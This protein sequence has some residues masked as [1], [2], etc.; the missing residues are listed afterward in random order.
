M[1][2]TQLACGMALLCLTT[3][4]YT[5]VDRVEEFK[6]STRNQIE[7][8]KSWNDMRRVYRDVDH[9]YHFK[10][11]YEAGYLD[12]ASGGDGCLPTLPPRCYWKVCYQNP[13]GRQKT[14][15]WFDG[16]AH[17]AIAAD[18]DGVNAYANIFTLKNDSCPVVAAPVHE[19]ADAEPEPEPDDAFDLLPP[20]PAIGTDPIENGPPAVPVPALERPYD[21]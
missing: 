9:T 5:F 13:K 1:K 16:F 12:V 11:G 3:G 6:M 14:I 19:N 21:S 20:N 17:G 8:R 15:A 18:K 10:S 4:C 2:Y 7:A